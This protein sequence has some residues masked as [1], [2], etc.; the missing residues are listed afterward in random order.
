MKFSSLNQGINDFRNRKFES[1]IMHFQNVLNISPQ[2]SIGQEWLCKALF[3]QGKI[4]Y[5]DHKINEAIEA[6]KASL[7]TAP[8][9]YQS[10]EIL[11]LVSRIQ[12]NLS[13]MQADFGKSCFIRHQYE[14]A[15]LSLTEALKLSPENGAI[16]KN[17]ARAHNDYGMS[18]YREA[19]ALKGDDQSKAK[20]LDSATQHLEFALQF[21]QDKRYI[22]SKTVHVDC[23]KNNL[24]NLYSELA[25]YLDE[26]GYPIRETLPYMIR[27]L[28]YQNDVKVIENMA[29]L[30]QKHK[31][32]LKSNGSWKQ[33][34]EIVG[35]VVHSLVGIEVFID[36]R[37]D[38]IGDNNGSISG[39]EEILST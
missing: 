20:L 1:A 28:S 38:L 33:T 37:T 32:E 8:L 15:I 6:L 22:C 21:T 10:Q 3:K 36:D 17:L 34:L 11:V 2:C 9:E 27:A 18:L 26:F 39:Q 7:A 16:I 4:L 23:I 35:A 13:N 29:V 14:D 12:Q 24:H 19:E 30:I 31:S 25:I 5:K